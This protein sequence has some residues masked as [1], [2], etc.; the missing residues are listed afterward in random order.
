MSQ[1]SETTAAADAANATSAC[2]ALFI[3]YAQTVDF[4]D[5]QRFVELFTEDAVLEL[6]F[7]LQGKENIRKSMTK[8]DPML[9]SRHVLTNIAINV[10]GA[11][12]A[13]GIA[14]LTLY[15][16]IGPESLQPE[17]VALR[18][19][20]AV[21]HYSNTFALT[22]QGW[23]IASCKLQLAFRDASHFP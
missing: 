20:A 14:Y 16:H 18:G 15:R 3:D 23:K 8:R 5:Y 13:E 9:R 12:S 2:T 4:A 10:T 22:T 17:A 6:G 7:R 1:T 11:D 19:P 21:G